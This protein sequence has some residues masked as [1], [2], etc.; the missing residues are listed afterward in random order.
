LLPIREPH[1]N[2]FLDL[3]N[4]F[5]PDLVITTEKHFEIWYGKDNGFEFNNKISLESFKGIIGQSLHLDVELMGK[6]D[7]VLPVCVDIHCKTS[8]IMIYSNGWHDVQVNFKDNSHVTW[9]FALD[10]GQR[11]TDTITMRGGDFNMDGYPDLLATLRSSE[12]QQTRSFLLENIPCDYN[13]GVF[14]RTFQ[15]RW[16]ALNPFFNE[17]VMAVFYDFYQDGMSFTFFYFK[18]N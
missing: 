2:A 17:S 15:V 8:L 12:T 10:G 9:G 16:N 6:M 18:I 7:L 1:A 4:D 14:N 3:N 11:Y 5:Y 13:C